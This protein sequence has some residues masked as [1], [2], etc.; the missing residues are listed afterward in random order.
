[1]Y[2]VYSEKL[3]KKFLNILEKKDFFNNFSD[4]H[5][6]IYIADSW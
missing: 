3:F 4:E 6:Y 5:L 2:K 1:M